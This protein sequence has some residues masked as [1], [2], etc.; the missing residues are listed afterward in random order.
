MAFFQGSLSELQD[1]MGSLTT[2]KEAKKL[3]EV[4]S[5]R[6]IQDMAEVRHLENAELDELMDE[7][8]RS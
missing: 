3:S 8:E 2:K 5:R 4:L 1:E 7:A 6:G